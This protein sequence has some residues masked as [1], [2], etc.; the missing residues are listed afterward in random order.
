MRSIKKIA[1]GVITI[2]VMFLDIALTAISI[3]FLLRGG[4]R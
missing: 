3:G 1:Y 2:L 4:G